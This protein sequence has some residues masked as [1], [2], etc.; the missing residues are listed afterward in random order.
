MGVQSLSLRR[1]PHIRAL[2]YVKHENSI[3]SMDPLPAL[4]YFLLPAY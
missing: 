2:T 3:D 4:V 1:V